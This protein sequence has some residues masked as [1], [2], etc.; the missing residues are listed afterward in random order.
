MLGTN[1]PCARNSTQADRGM[2]WYS[3]RKL[4]TTFSKFLE[5]RAFGL[6]S[7]VRFH[8]PYRV[9]GQNASKQSRMVLSPTRFMGL[10]DA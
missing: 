4:A 9:T 2:H 5:I 3:T 7:V 8:T 6:S 1:P 10:W